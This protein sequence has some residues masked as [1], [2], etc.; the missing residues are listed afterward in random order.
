MRKIEKVRY[1]IDP[2]ARL[3]RMRQVLDGEFVID[4]NN[5]LSYRVKKPLPSSCPSQIRLSGNWALDKEHN[6]VLAL[7]SENNRISGDRLTLEGEIIDASANE[8]AFSVR[9]RDIKGQSHFYLLKLGG[10]WQADRYN[11]LSFLVAREKERAD[12]LTL[13]GAWE[14]N[15]RNQLVYTFTK[16]NPNK[17]ERLTRTLTFKGYWDISEKNRITYVLNKTLG[18]GFN[19]RV[20]LGKPAK[21]GLEYEVGIGMAPRKKRVALSGSWKVNPRLGLVF[22]MPCEEGKIRALVFGAECRPGKGTDLEFRLRNELNKDLGVS[23][24]LSKAILGDSGTAFVEALK[25][26][27]NISIFA[28]MGFRW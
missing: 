27:G 15:K 18:S 8:L 2:D 9:T 11:R 12:T 4:K 28:G 5:A 22:E 13:A 21:R 26:R 17:K 10:K 1:G 20:G 23:L 6:L 16:L 14:V 3:I 19:F 25:E 7:D 24:R